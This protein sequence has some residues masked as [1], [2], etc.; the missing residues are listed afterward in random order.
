MLH[1]KKIT[2]NGYSHVVETNRGVV[3]FPKG[4]VTAIANS[5]GIKEFEVIIDMVKKEFDDKE[6]DLS[7]NLVTVKVEEKPVQVTQPTP[8]PVQ[9]Q[10]PKATSP[11]P[12]SR[13]PRLVPLMVGQK[14]REDNE[15]PTMIKKPLDIPIPQPAKPPM[16]LPV[17]VPPVKIEE[18]KKEEKKEEK[19]NYAEMKY[20][21]VLKAAN[22]KGYKGKSKKKEDMVAWLNKK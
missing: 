5:K 16:P 22:E 21:E 12:P 1:V 2:D 19:P 20:T 11:P 3:S 8:K 17:V 4:N 6:V 18:P 15:Y 10:M 13:H 7:P 14:S 9:P